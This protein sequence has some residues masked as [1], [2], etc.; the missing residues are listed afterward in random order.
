MMEL[1]KLLINIIEQI[2]CIIR[3]SMYNLRIFKQYI[4]FG[5]LLFLKEYFYVLPQS[6]LIVMEN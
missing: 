2:I 3:H 6:Q 4:Y 5:K 1:L